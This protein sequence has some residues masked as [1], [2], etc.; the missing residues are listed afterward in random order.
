M[1][2]QKKNKKIKITF[3]YD[4]KNDWMINDLRKMKI[5]KKYIVKFN[6]NYKKIK[7]QNIVF[8]INLLKILPLK[9]L[10]QNSLNLVVHSSKLPKDKGFSPLFNQILRGKKTF[11]ISLIEAVEK[12]D[13]G[14]I[15]LQNKFKISNSLLNNEIKNEEKKQ[16]LRIIKNFLSIY[17][18]FKRKKQIGLGSFNKKRNFFSNK[19]NINKT[20]KSQFNLLRI[21]HNEKYPAF[22]EHNK[23]L[24]KIKIYNMNYEKK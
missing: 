2:I 11:Y 8:F 22:F 4:K 5:P 23:R 20:L 18:N 15:M 14:D 9:F 1:V 13:S 24:Y 21:S 12:V 3:L 17:P 7:N 16:F 19:I 6:S 10:K